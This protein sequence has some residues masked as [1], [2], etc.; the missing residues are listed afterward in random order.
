MTTFYVSS[1]LCMIIIYLVMPNPEILFNTKKLTNNILM[2][3][4]ILLGYYYLYCII[5]S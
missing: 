3:Y 1:A 2:Y 4:E 5:I